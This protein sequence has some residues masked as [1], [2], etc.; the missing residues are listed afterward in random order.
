MQNKNKGI[1]FITTVLITGYLIGT[2]THVIHFSE[3]I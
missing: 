2:M 1:A 3:V